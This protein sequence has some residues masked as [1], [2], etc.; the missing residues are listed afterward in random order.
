MMLLALL[1]A[2]IPLSQPQT[3]SVK[4]ADK[5]TGLYNV[6]LSLQICLFLVDFFQN[7]G[8]LK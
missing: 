5:E 3:T 6:F 8:I 2:P 1:K 4:K 7:N